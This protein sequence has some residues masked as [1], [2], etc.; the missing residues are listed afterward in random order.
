MRELRTGG[1]PGLQDMI[2]SF[3]WWSWIFRLLWQ[4][5]RTWLLVLLT[6][7]A[8]SGVS[9]SMQVL[10]T[11]YL[12]DSVTQGL[13]ADFRRALSVVLLYTAFT[14]GR[15]ALVVIQQYLQGMF[16]IDLANSIHTRVLKKAKELGLAEFEDPKTY[17]ML[18]RAQRDSATRPYQVLEQTLSIIGGVIT[19]ISV[20]AVLVAW[21][22]WLALLL[23]GIPLSSVFSF[24]SQNR[25]EYEAQFQRTPLQR[26]AWYLGHLLTTD[27]YM[28][29][30]KLFQLQDLILYRYSKLLRR[31]REVDRGLQIRR[32]SISL[33][34]YLLGQ[35]AV[36]GSLLLVIWHAV[37][38]VLSAGSVAAY[39]QAIYAVQS[40]TEGLL[41]SLFAMYQNNLYVAQLSAFLNL[42][43]RDSVR[44]PRRLSVESLH[45]IEFRQ[46]TFRYP[47]A[48]RNALENVSFRIR[49]GETIAVVGGNGSG[50]STIV[51]LLSGLY[52]P[53]AGCVLINGRPIQQ[54][55][56]EA[57]RLR[58]AVV[59]QDFTRYELPARENVG[60]GDLRRLSD[61]AAL[62]EAARRAGADPIVA[63][64]P[65][66]LSTQLGR[67]FEGGVQLSGGQWQKIAI[68]RAF[69][70]E[71]DLFVLDEPSAALDPLAEGEVFD[72][73]QQLTT[74]R[75]GIFISHRYSSLRFASRILVLDEG[76]LVE[77][78]NHASLMASDGVYA[79]YYRRQASAFVDG[80]KK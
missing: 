63:S 69:L 41:R 47:G 77:S 76:R 12:L 54:Y 35:T 29:E 9:V 57:L 1:S 3:Q 17:D 43:V 23:L 31:F 48:Q 13:V 68:S 56:Q 8:L 58:M 38:G 2:Q 44:Q 36:G 22:W 78:G 66:G 37:L 20:G 71:A 75:M 74:D 34:C 27:S 46:V 4:T 6:L 73:F 5:N 55:D 10:L 16:Q 7:H 53:T 21:K 62:T 15:Q 60:F 67:W 18:Q 70:R 80:D 30:V 65:E 39:F 79:R 52:E 61:D 19:L 72:R 33:Q 32:A 26:L 11:Q 50:K 24:L 40:A 64:L 49:R 42:R 25:M 59:L 28:K 45:E 14:I 51:N